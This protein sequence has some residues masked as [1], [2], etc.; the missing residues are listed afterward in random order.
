M[1]S[2]HNDSGGG[3]HSCDPASGQA[4]ATGAEGAG[5]AVRGRL[6][7]HHQAQRQDHQPAQGV[8]M[9]SS[10]LQPDQGMRCLSVGH[11]PKHCSTYR[12]SS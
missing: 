1:V 11:L 5:A 6:H 9:L 2:G 7:H 3:G 8:C 10:D 4:E 12:D